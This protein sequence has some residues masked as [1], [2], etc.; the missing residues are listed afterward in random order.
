[1]KSTLKAVAVISCL[2]FS[3]L[4]VTAQVNDAGL[5]ASISIEKKLTQRLSLGFTEEARFNENISELGTL[6]SDIGL[7]YK[8]FG[9]EWLGVSANYRFI[10][11]KRLDD[12]YSTR[13]RWYIDAVVKKK[14]G[15]LVP[16]F[17]TRFQSQYADVFTSDAG[18]K[19]DHYTRNK[20]TLKL[21]MEKKYKPFISA[22]LFTQLNDGALLNDNVRYAAGVDYSFN[23][24][25]AFGIG[26][27]V[28]RE[29]NVKNP[30]HNYIVTL[31]YAYSF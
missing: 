12:S 14:F 15:M 17:R 8:F 20:L 28:E 25:S 6:F 29:M 21:D 23:E 9:G 2:L 22:E 1:M 30:E 13:H 24:H 16:S 27:L 3:T 4:H 19:A 31:G 11:K 26:Y 10:D 5:W 7:G 18:W